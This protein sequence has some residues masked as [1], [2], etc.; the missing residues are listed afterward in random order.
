MSQLDGNAAHMRV[1]AA[2]LLTLPGQP[3]SFFCEY[4][5]LR[6]VKPD[7]DL[8]EPMR[9]ERNAHATGETTWKA[10][11][12]GAD[13][14]ISVQAE[15][16]NRASLLSRYMMLIHWRQQ[17]S[18]L[19]DGTLSAFDSGNPHVLGWQLADASSQVLVL[20]NLSSQPQRVTLG[21]SSRYRT[22]RL[23]T[24]DDV[25]LHGGSLELPPDTSVVLE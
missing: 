17:V 25:R 23:A 9:W 22:I 24:G 18:A 11:S 19:R 6:G 16:A 12:T 1:A 21:G 14:D 20:H 3:F 10:S 4:L 7:P 8:R 2:M 13:P 15:L 5:G